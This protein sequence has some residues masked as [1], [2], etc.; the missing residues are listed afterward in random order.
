MIARLEVVR[1]MLLAVVAL[2]GCTES[3]TP[4]GPPDEIDALALVVPTARSLNPYRQAGERHNLGMAFALHELREARARAGDAW[5]RDS[6]IPSVERAMRR[7]AAV[8]GREVGSETLLRLLQAHLERR[9]GLRSSRVESDVSL[10]PEASALL[11]SVDAL[12]DRYDLDVDQTLSAL[13]VIEQEA[14]ELA[15]P[16]EMEAVL[17]YASVAANSSVY[18][19]TQATAWESL[20]EPPTL[21]TL[22]VAPGLALSVSG[23]RGWFDWRRVVRYDVYG[24]FAG[25]VACAWTGGAV[26]GCIVGGAIAGSVFSAVEQIGEHWAAQ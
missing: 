3:P 10:S 16:I 9:D 24:A 25:M 21:Q 4:A 19:Q 18:W 26:S 17:S 12:M 14:A 13:G 1:C 22:V 5:A 11:S 2:A 6:I 7:F 8:K 20:T 23:T 15:D